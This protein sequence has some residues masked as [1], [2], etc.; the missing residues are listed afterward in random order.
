MYISKIYIHLNLYTK[1]HT[2]NQKSLTFTVNKILYKSST[3][4][5]IS[6]YISLQLLEKTVKVI[7][8]LASLDLSGSLK[9]FLVFTD[10]LCY[11]LVVK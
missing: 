4:E 9:S 10:I 8:A 7:N 11:S 1:K 6:M 5:L 3:L 2:K